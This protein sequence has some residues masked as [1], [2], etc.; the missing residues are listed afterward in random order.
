MTR[1]EVLALIRKDWVAFAA[2][3]SC[4]LSLVSILLPMPFRYALL[5][6]ATVLWVMAVVAM[7]RGMRHG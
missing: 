2:V 3:L 7:I 5:I 4:V 1:D 6:P